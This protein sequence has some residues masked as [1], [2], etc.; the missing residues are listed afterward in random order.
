MRLPRRAVLAALGLVPLIS[1]AAA[2]A[3]LR[4]A[5][6]AR[7]PAGTDHLTTLTA[8]PDAAAGR[9]LSAA[10]L[11]ARGHGLA[12]HP[13]GRMAVMVARRP[14]RFA[15]AFD[16]L[17]G[18]RLALFEPIDGRHFYGHGAFTETGLLALTENAFETGDGVLGLY[19]PTDR[20]ARVGE[21]RTG[22][23][24]PH[25]V[26][27]GKGGGLLIVG[28]GGI[29]THPDTGRTKLNLETMDPS[30][31]VL[32]GTDGSPIWQAGLP[33]ALRWL[34]LRHLTLAA[35]RTLVVA[36]QWE[37]PGF[38]TPPLIAVARNG[39]PLQPV[40]APAPI[41][42]RMANYC[43]SIAADA[44]GRWIAVSHP[45]GGIVTLWRLDSD[46]VHFD[47]GVELPDGSG[48]A[49]F[50]DAAGRFLLTAGTGRVI[51]HDAV[52][53]DIRPFSTGGPPRRWDNHIANLAASA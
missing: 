27:A 4:F 10:P 22:G 18:E 31:A 15:I 8:D 24:G 43:G 11:P 47:H 33:T 30:V 14:G 21:L 42:R 25:E 6:S 40:S 20:F 3:G 37:G 7:D 49:P 5:A 9:A 48:V 36:G 46:G 41:Q 38:E 12:V 28:N 39:G 45:R 26:I 17:S 2:E 34:S 19:D 29:R 50:G 51:L 35:D 52:S 16:P 32:S 1:P 13:S 23:V 53:Q 44:S